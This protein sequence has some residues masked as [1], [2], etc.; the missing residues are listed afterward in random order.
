MIEGDEGYEG[1]GVR[2]KVLYYDRGGVRGQVVREG[3][4]L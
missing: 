2:E 4:I 1:A 3:F